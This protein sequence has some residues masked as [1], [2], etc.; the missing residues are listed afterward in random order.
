MVTVQTIEHK[1][2]RAMSHSLTRGTIV[3]RLNIA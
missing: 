1:L 3:L 2:D